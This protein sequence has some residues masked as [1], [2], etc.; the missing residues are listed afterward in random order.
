MASEATRLPTISWPNLILEINAFSSLKCQINCL[1]EMTDFQEM[2]G[3]R[4]M[5]QNGMDTERPTIP[6][7]DPKPPLS[8]L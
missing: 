4:L 1:N 7:D 6:F 5:E 8:L 3:V 2:V